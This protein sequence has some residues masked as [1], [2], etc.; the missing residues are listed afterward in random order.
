M[1]T[2]GTKPPARRFEL[3]DDAPVGGFDANTFALLDRAG[4]GA[5]ELAAGLGLAQATYGPLVSNLQQQVRD[6]QGRLSEAQ[7]QIREDR[8]Q[9]RADLRATEDRYREKLDEA[10]RDADKAERGL[11][12]AELRAELKRDDDS[13]P[14]ERLAEPLMQSIPALA[15]ALQGQHV[16][17]QPLPPAPQMTLADVPATP[18]GAAAQDTI[19]PVQMRAS[20]LARFENAL[21]RAATDALR[22]GGDVGSVMDGAMRTALQALAGVGISPDPSTLARTALRFALQSMDE[23]QPARVVAEA[24]RPVVDATGQAAAILATLT[25]ENAANTLAI[26]AGTTLPP[27]AQPFVAE[28]IR[29]LVRPETAA[30]PPAVDA[31]PAGAGPAETPTPAPQGAHR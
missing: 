31:S 5:S 7:D 21:L 22:S 11:E 12:I 2:T 16:P 25:P 29:A 4:T 23:G 19:D 9:H 28:V 13:S 15:A 26:L 14:I 1:A 18:H 24:L 10:R 17:A 6:F 27:E 30:A 8:E 3:D 20:L